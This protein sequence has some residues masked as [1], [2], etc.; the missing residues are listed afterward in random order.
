MIATMATLAG[1]PTLTMAS[2]LALNSGFNRMA[3]GG[4]ACREPVCLV[5]ARRGWIAF[6]GSGRCPSGQATRPTRLAAWAC[7]RRLSSGVSTTSSVCGHLADAW[8]ARQDVGTAGT[9]PSPRCAAF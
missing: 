6:H 8:N 5:G 1:F 4:R 9:G 2:Y 3:L 7:S